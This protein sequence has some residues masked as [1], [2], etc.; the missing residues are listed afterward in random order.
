M[1]NVQKQVDAQWFATDGDALSRDAALHRHSNKLIRAAMVQEPLQAE[2]HLRTARIGVGKISDDDFPTMCQRA[3]QALQHLQER[4]IVEV[5]E[6]P[7]GPDQVVLLFRLPF[8]AVLANEGD[9][10][11]KIPVKRGGILNCVRVYLDAIEHC[12]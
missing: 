10:V 2:F 5:I 12:S 7:G 11:E 8:Q 1:H 9:A 3:E 4:C 6:Y